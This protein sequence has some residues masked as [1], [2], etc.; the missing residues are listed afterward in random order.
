MINSIANI[1]PQP[2][3][4]ELEKLIKQIP[5]QYGWYSHRQQEYTPHWNCNFAGTGGANGLDISD[6]IHGALKDAWNHV[7]QTYFPNAR[8]LRCYTNAHTYGVEGYP[9]TDSIRKGEVTLVIYCNRQWQRD[10]GGETMIYDGNKII[11]AELPSFNTGLFFDSDTYH[12]ARAVTR[13]CK[14]LR[15]T[16]MFKMSVG[17]PDTQRDELQKFLNQAQTENIPHRGSTLSNH[18]LRNYDLLQTKN[19]PPHVCLAGGSHSL[20][21]TNKFT[22]V[23]LQLPQDIDRL[24]NIIG[25]QAF[26]LVKFFSEIDRPTILTQWLKDP[27]VAVKD[28]DG[29]QA[30]TQQIQELV[31]IECANLLEQKSLKK[32]PELEQW[33]DDLS[34]ETT[35]ATTG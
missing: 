2:I 8:L 12:C 25:Q 1:I 23:A 19:Q 15:I 16:L 18:L 6:R 9:H 29:N 10:W 4:I 3:C 20:L 5:W 27:T 35:T 13:A 21:G 31:T 7:Q 32:H 22:T 26:D 34:R 14:E 33:W 11:H 28:R 30:S 17:E 24:K